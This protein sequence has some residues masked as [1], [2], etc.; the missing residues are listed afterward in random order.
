MSRSLVL[1]LAASM[2]GAVGEAS[3]HVFQRDS[4]AADSIPLHDLPLHP[5]PARAPGPLALFITGDGGWA[6]ADRE[7]A[8]TLADRGIA[9]VAWDA[10]AYLRK[11]ARSPAVVASD[12]ERIIEYYMDAWKREDVVLIGYSRGADMMPFIANR[13]EP[14]V[15]N[16]VEL[17]ALVGL[18][19]RASFEFHWTD[20]IRDVRRATDLPVQ[21]ELER[22]R[23]MRILCVYGEDERDSACR[24]AE[25]GLV[26]SVGRDGAAH[27]IH[28]SDASELAE[29]IEEA[30]R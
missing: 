24:G 12:A 4:V 15:R 13:L 16:H 10:R 20:L 19:T 11:H 21:P 2:L 9:V 29:M 5:V 30:L 7:L 14:R 1:L 25:R 23:G 22:L 6:A 8:K 18:S 28:A 26:T 17:L 3:A 27:Q